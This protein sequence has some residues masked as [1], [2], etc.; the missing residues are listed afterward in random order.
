MNHADRP[1][2]R[3]A[4]L[5]RSPGT[6]RSFK[7]PRLP[8]GI[9]AALLVVAAAS[10]SPAAIRMPAVISDHAILQAGKPDALWGWASAGD[11]I[12]V[13][14]HGGEAKTAEFKATADA[15]GRWSGALP[16]LPAGTAGQLE[17]RTAKGESRK[18]DDVLIGEVWLCGGQSN[19]SY[20]VNSPSSVR[21]EATTPELLAAAKSEAAAA[22]GSLR[23]FQTNFRV[24][25]SPLEDVE[26]RWIVATPDSVGGCFA[27]SWNFAVALHDKIHQPIGLLDSAV[28]GTVIEAWTPKPELDACPAGPDLEKR[29][30]E[31]FDRYSPAVKAKYEAET[32]EWTKKYPTPELQAQHIATKPLPGGNNGNIPARLYNG[33]IHGFE[34]YTLQGVIW[35]QGDG[36]CGHPQDY[37]VLFKTLIEAWRAHFQNEHLPFYYVEMQNYGKPQQKPV[38]PNALSEIREQQ[39]AVLDL[40]DT[41]VATGVDQGIRIPN[42]EA[43]FPDKKQLGQ[44]LAG[45]AL[46]HLYNQPGLVHSPRFKRLK[47]EGNK[48]R[49]QFEYA[50]GLRIRGGGELSGFAIRAGEGPWVWAKGE[51]QGQEIVLWS[52]EVPTPSAVRYAWAYNPTLSVENSAGLPLRPFRTDPDSK[53]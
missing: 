22:A 18:I 52:D 44:R 21:N 32:A 11:E 42:Y 2:R 25:D 36:N 27:L 23:Y 28:G 4:S 40:P 20:L 30:Q 16:A 17:I 46:D 6:Y 9:T 45:L 8:S 34:P 7:S 47:I 41:D 48:V 51:I 5:S 12:T 19:M 15:D 39:Q 33:M 31:M 14:F 24:C 13:T 1:F 10:A 37:G 35:F 49:L 26:G 29:Y 38:E 50:D 53:Q 43:H 3:L